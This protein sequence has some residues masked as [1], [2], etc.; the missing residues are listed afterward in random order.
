M[1]APLYYM[2]PYRILKEGKQKTMVWKKL[3]YLPVE[4]ESFKK[5]RIRLLVR[6]V[7]KVFFACLI[8]QLLFSLITIH[9]ISW[10][11]IVYVVLAGFAIP[12]LVNALGII[13]EK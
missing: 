6:Y 2:L 7:G 10:A 5:W 11:N 1:Y 13:L 3:K 4:L 9:R 12:M 8:I